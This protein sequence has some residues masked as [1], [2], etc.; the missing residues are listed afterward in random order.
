MA[1]PDKM[2][3]ETMPVVPAADSGTSSC[4]IKVVGVGGAGG[5][6]VLRMINTGVE[7]VGFAAIN[8]DAQALS[9]FKGVATTLN[10]GKAVTRGLGAGTY[11]H[12]TL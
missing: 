8:T 2:V 4:V 1:T 9:K 7:G 12:M 6:A 11:G 3:V 10:I 5:N